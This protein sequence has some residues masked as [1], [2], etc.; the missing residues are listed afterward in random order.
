M[1]HMILNIHN[2]VI[3]DCPYHANEYGYL[4]CVNFISFGTLKATTGYI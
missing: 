1:L 4:K 3:I 2:S